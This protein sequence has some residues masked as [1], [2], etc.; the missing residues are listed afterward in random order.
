V[1]GLVLGLGLGLE[2]DYFQSIV[3]FPQ[4]AIRVSVRVKVKVRVKVRVRDRLFP[5][6]C[7]IFS[8]SDKG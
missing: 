4:R 8:E 1:L 7:E 6:Y 3:N 5:K 2:I